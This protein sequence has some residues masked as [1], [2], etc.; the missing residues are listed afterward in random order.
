[1]VKLGDKV[2]DPIS[3]FEGVIVST[4][5]YQYGCTRMSVQPPVDKDGKLP[6]IQSFDE[7]ALEL[8]KAQVAVPDPKPSRQ[9]TGGPD[10]YPDTSKR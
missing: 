2:R 6:E 7:P 10:K 8:V 3:G 9:R 4:H 1:M 5:H